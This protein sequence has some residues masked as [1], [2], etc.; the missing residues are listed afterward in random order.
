MRLFGRVCFPHIVLI[1]FGQVILRFF[2]RAHL[3]DVGAFEIR[4]LT[5]QELFA[6]FV[7]GHDTLERLI[8]RH[9]IHP[10][11]VWVAGVV[12][13]LKAEPVVERFGF[14]FRDDTSHDILHEQLNAHSVEKAH[15][16]WIILGP[17]LA[18]RVTLTR[19][20]IK[21]LV[22]NLDFGKG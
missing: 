21:Y 19:D 8:S 2:P 10:M 12:S 9:V 15:N 22:L 5:F 16:V 1:E 3:D 18:E 7:I 11:G 13:K 6:C 4:V 14:G 20:G 17:L